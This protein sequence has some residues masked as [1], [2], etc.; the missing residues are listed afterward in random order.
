MELPGAAPPSPPLSP[1]LVASHFGKDPVAAF[2]RQLM[3]AA[4]E[5]RRLPP[6][7]KAASSSSVTKNI[8]DLLSGDEDGK[9]PPNVGHHSEIEKSDHLLALKLQEEAWVRRFLSFSLA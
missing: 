1:T 7:T 6:S 3:A 9:I 2:K 8:V 5:A 4:A